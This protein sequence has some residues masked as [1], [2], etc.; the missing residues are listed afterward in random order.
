MKSIDHV[1]KKIA[2]LIT[3]C[4][5]CMDIQFDKA[6]IF[7]SSVCTEPKKRIIIVTA[8]MSYITHKMT[9]A[10]GSNDLKIVSMSKC[11]HI[12]GIENKN[13]LGDYVKM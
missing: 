6:C 4:H 11:F 12:L 3:H 5:T 9:H 8:D 10:S 1:H 7:F 2:R 13:G